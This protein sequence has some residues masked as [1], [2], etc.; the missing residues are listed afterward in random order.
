[1]ILIKNSSGHLISTQDIDGME[2]TPY[3]AALFFPTGGS[4]V[5]AGHRDIVNKLVKNA[6]W[7]DDPF[8]DLLATAS[9][10]GDRTFNQALSERRLASTLAALTGAGVSMGK[11]TKSRARGEDLAAQVGVADGNNDQTWRACLISVNTTNPQTLTAQLQLNK[12]A[13]IYSTA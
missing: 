11:V 5:T 2:D 6:D 1:M 9:R 3:L 4:T 12:V 13:K 8:Y 7:V 10:L